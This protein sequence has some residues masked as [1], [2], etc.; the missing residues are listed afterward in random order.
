MRGNFDRCQKQKQNALNFLFQ[1]DI[2]SFMK[3]KGF[4]KP[5]SFISSTFLK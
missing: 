3:K 1:P 2:V 5:Y 4:T